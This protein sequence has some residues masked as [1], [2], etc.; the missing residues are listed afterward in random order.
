MLHKVVTYAQL[1]ELLLE[2]GFEDKS[3]GEY[4][5]FHHAEKD[6][7]IMMAHHSLSTL[8][9]EHD[10]LQ[11]RSTLDWNGLLAK[12]EFETWLDEAKVKSET[13]AAG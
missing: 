8:A 7:S 6:T 5:V 9:L 12:D 3:T 2:H 13:S 4:L 11:V 10:V 1:R